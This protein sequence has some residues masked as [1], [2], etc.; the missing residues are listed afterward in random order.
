VRIG[1][2]GH[3]LYLFGV[4]LLHNGQQVM[5]NGQAQNDLL[6]EAYKERWY[7]A[8]SLS[9][10]PEPSVY[11]EAIW[12]DKATIRERVLELNRKAGLPGFA[13]AQALCA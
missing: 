5:P 10:D 6:F 11:V 12:A 7:K 13:Q 4:N 2:R 3:K 1:N 8:E 9:S